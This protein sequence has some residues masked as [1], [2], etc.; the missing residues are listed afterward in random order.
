MLTIEMAKAGRQEEEDL[1]ARKQHGSIIKT[2]RQTNMKARKLQA[3]CNK[4]K[5]IYKEFIKLLEEFW[6]IRGMPKTPKRREK[7]G[8][9]MLGNQSIYLKEETRLYDIPEADELKIHGL[10]L[11]EAKEEVEEDDDSLI[12]PHLRG[13]TGDSCLPGASQELAINVRVHEWEG[14][15]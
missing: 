10:G 1:E 2:L 11:M 7:A 5:R 12:D 3:A 9:N 13:I 4:S 15:W 8:F 14:L 6:L